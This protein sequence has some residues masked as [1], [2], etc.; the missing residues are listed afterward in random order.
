[1]SIHK[2]TA[3]ITRTGSDG[4]PQLLVFRHPEAGVQLPAGTGEDGETSES[5]VLREA[6]EETGLSC[7]WLSCHL[8]T[9]TEQLPEGSHMLQA[10]VRVLQ[11]PSPFSDSLPV[12][13]GGGM[14]VE[15]M[16]R[17]AT[18]RFVEADSTGDYARVCFDLFEARDGELF[19]VTETYGW[20]PAAALSREVTRHHFHLRTTLETADAWLH[21]GDVPGCELFWLSFAEASQTLVPPQKLWLESVIDRLEAATVRDAAKSD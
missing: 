15:R 12:P 6:W 20:V 9:S 16:L 21:D 13:M 3:Y 10:T 14:W 1:M 17:G 11:E 5:S 2:V 18:C 4:L 19:L 7:L 8:H